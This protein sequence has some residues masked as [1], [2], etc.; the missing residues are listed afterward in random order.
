MVDL[1]SGDGTFVWIARTKFIGN[2]GSTLVY[3]SNASGPNRY[4]SALQLTS[5]LFAVNT[6]SG[7]LILS[8]SSSPWF[9]NNTVV[10][11]ALGGAVVDVSGFSSSPESD[12]AIKRN[13]IIQPASNAVNTNGQSPP[14]D[15]ITTNLTTD[16]GLTLI[17]PSN[18][19]A[20]PQFAPGYRLQRTSPA[21]DRTIL[22][23]TTPLDLAGYPRPVDR[24][25]VPNTGGTADLGAY[26]LQIDATDA[27]FRS[28]F[29]P[30]SQ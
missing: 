16:D 2:T 5:N 27:V 15:S 22:G 18:F 4:R 11:N 19:N 23:A 14:V 1:E 25:D 29:E 6:L 9:L 7:A 10:A 26:E 17:D 8:Q 21:V 28:G 24:P 13:I 20:D 3:R 12:L 30:Q